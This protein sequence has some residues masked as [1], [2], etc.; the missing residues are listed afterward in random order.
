MP[1]CMWGSTVAIATFEAGYGGGRADSLL[2][3]PVRTPLPGVGLATSASTSSL[4]MQQAPVAVQLP[5]GLVVPPCVPSRKAKLPNSGTYQ[6]ERERE[7][8]RGRG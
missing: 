3:T 8:E 2:R 4:K 1:T 7:R 6:R 5:P